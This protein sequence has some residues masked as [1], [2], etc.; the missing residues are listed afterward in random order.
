M[1]LD[2]RLV[3]IAVGIAFGLFAGVFVARKSAA[4]TPVYGGAAAR[5]LHYLACAAFS[6]SFP[7]AIVAL[8]MRQGV[9]NALIDGLGFALASLILCGLFAL[10]ERP[11]ALRH[12]EEGWTEAKARSSGL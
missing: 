1:T 8:V 9:G 7:S 4:M 2:P 6:G 11:A 12:Q 10:A 5:I 3:S